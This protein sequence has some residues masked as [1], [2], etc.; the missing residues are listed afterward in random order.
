MNVACY[1]CCC[2]LIV[3]LATIIIVLIDRCIKLKIRDKELKYGEKEN[4]ARRDAML[5]NQ[6]DWKSWKSMTE[7]LLKT[8]EE[9]IK[10]WIEH[11]PIR[12]LPSQQDTSQ[13]PT[14]QTNNNESP[15]N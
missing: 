6:S 15:N 2:I 8:N 10:K 11:G 12:E 14:S 4:Q 9:I 3:A 1:V 13:T 5:N 7:T